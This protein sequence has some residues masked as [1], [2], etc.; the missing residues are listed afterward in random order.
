[1]SKIEELKSKIIENDPSILELKF[2]CKTDKGTITSVFESQG[3]Y[4]YAI[5]PSGMNWNGANGQASAYTYSK[6]RLGKIIGREITLADVLR[7]LTNK[8]NPEK[9][10]FWSVDCNG[11]FTKMYGAAWANDHLKE[12]FAESK[13][14][15]GMWEECEINL[16]KNTSWNFCYDLEHQEPQVW[17]FLL[18]I[19][20]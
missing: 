4:A 11:F 1:M 5:T 15:R 8:G 14:A 13:I 3:V 16:T 7:A 2:G 10:M 19:T 12:E 6:D 17:D 18:S 9:G 20:K